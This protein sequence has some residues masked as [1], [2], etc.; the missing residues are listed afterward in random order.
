M[1]SESAAKVKL[2]TASP[3]DT[4]RSSYSYVFRR[5]YLC[6][7]PDELIEVSILTDPRRVMHNSISL[8][9][10]PRS[11]IGDQTY[12]LERCHTC[13][14][15][16]RDDDRKA[17]EPKD[18]ICALRSIATY[19]G[20]VKRRTRRVSSLTG[21]FARA[22]RRARKGKV[23]EEE[24]VSCAR[25][26]EAKIAALVQ[27]P[28]DSVYEK[29]LRVVGELTDLH[30]QP[31]IFGPRR[32]SV[33]LVPRGGVL[34]DRRNTNTANDA[35]ASA[36]QSTHGGSDDVRHRRCEAASA[37]RH[38][39]AV[40]EQNKPRNTSVGADAKVLKDNGAAEGSHSSH[41]DD[42][43]MPSHFGATASADLQ[44][45][46]PD[47]PFD[48]DQ[49]ELDPANNG[50]K[51]MKDL[52]HM[53]VP[54]LTDRDDRYDQLITLD[55]V[56][57][58]EH[59]EEGLQSADSP[60]EMDSGYDTSESG[61]SSAE[62]LAEQYLRPIHSMQE[63]LPIDING[64]FGSYY[65][66]TSETRP[67]LGAWLD[68]YGTICDDESKRQSR[69]SW[70]SSIYSDD[71]PDDKGVWW[72]PIRP[73]VVK[74]DVEPPP[75]IPRRN[76][77]RLLKR[78]SKTEP[79]GYGEEKRG[80]RN[81]HNLHLDL[82]RSNSKD[83]RKSIQS[84][85]PRQR[86]SWAPAKKDTVESM[87][88][89]PQLSLII[90]GHISNAM[91]NSVEDATKSRR[92]TMEST[93]SRKYSIVH[94]AGDVARECRASTASNTQRRSHSG[95]NTAAQSTTSTPTM[96][97]PYG[98]SHSARQ[99]PRSSGYAETLRSARG[100][101]RGFS[102]P[103]RNGS[104]SD[105]SSKWNASMPPQETVRRSCI[106]SLVNGGT[107]KRRVSHSAAINK[108]LPPLPVDMGLQ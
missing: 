11:A 78:M 68:N 71:S 75:P 36:F 98:G 67:E 31:R 24:T 6:G 43:S 63:L 55:L 30:R 44:W 34:Q 50:R 7:H 16:Q 102:E 105:V 92:T 83:V 28:D 86:D 85:R 22:L 108:R 59:V 51:A 82:S 46:D 89:K 4:T 99:T 95:Q 103:V 8:G 93:C 66:P 10:I 20:A 84:P 56:E 54:L 42:F 60:P 18:K 79:K 65:S 37:H 49:S 77:L 38:S 90:P 5:V 32:G 41:A 91:R 52:H 100:H 69:F 1:S 76:P 35:R 57:V 88:R 29:A 72:K 80:S 73:L 15:Q 2:E 53:S 97:K 81:I 101:A 33:P 48:L 96:I 47:G 45:L 27:S 104:V 17:R 74:K 70:T 64:R 106:A 13:V 21:G 40:A 62:E 25:E 9:D 107:T 39:A 58:D 61:R 12:S 19:Q 87:G 14:K 3:H 23:G 26:R 94:S